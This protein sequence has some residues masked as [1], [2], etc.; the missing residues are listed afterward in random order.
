MQ[1][2]GV[3]GPVSSVKRIL[4]IVMQVAKDTK[5][6]NEKN[7]EFVSL[8]YE[9]ITEIA[10]IIDVNS[11]EIKIWLF[12]AAVPFVLAKQHLG[13]EENL[14]YCN[15]AGNELYKCFLEMSHC[16]EKKVLRASVDVWS[17]QSSALEAELRELQMPK[18]EIIIQTYELHDDLESLIQSHIALWKAG[19]V[20]AVITS[21]QAVYDSLKGQGIPVY[22]NAVT[23]S[24]VCKA[25]RDVYGKIDSLYFKNSQVGLEFIEIKNYEKFVEKVGNEYKLQLEELKIIEKLIPLCQKIDGYLLEKGNGH[26]EIFSSRGR[27]SNGITILQETMEDIG[28]EIDAE[29]VA[30]IGFGETF[31]LARLNARKALLCA[32]SKANQNI[33]IIMDDGGIVESVGQEDEVA[34]DSSSNDKVLL[35]RLKEVDVGIKTYRKVQ[36]TVKRMKWE[37]FTTVQLAAQLAIAERS[38]RR[39]LA[40]LCKACLVECIG[41]EALSMRGRPTRKYIL[42]K[43]E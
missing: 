4:E 8:P 41:E 24:S 18:Q 36:A 23:H 31:F 14:V 16:Q 40:G 35:E 37:A 11:N 15:V 12:S 17:G 43:I 6:D 19:T 30:G 33:V 7:V 21:R 1:K 3:V 22:R 27:I 9:K 39:I 20:D 34:Y 10:D 29:L 42:S 32:A 13:T 38:A 5:K 28:L 26:Y 2:I 25:I